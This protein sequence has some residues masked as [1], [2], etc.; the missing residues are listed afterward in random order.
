MSLKFHGKDYS[1]LVSK[2]LNRFSREDP[3]FQ[4]SYDEDSKEV[5]DVINARYLHQFFSVDYRFWDG[6]AT[7]RDLCSADV[8]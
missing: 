4:V 6:R 7:S 8:K 1:G 3:T 5:S 2:A